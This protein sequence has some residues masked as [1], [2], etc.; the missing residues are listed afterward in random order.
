MNTD[1][2]PHLRADA[3]QN[4]VRIVA[5]ARAAFA[6]DGLDV[7]MNEIARRA[8]VGQGTL[9]RRFPTKEALIDEVFADHV[10]HC[11]NMVS[12]GLR[13]PDPWRGFCTVVRKM[14]M[15]L[16][17]DRSFA[18]VLTTRVTDESSVRSGRRAVET[19]LEE[20]VRRTQVAGRL[21]A[22]FEPGDI[23]LTILANDGV[24]AAV[25]DP[26]A[27]CERLTAYL[28]RAFEAGTDTNALPTA[29]AVGLDDL[30]PP[31]RSGA[32]GRDGAGSKPERRRRGR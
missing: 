15:A 1:G 2:G 5:A 26:R 28:L 8:G 12:A 24:A 19:L 22:D 21:R 32:T 29:I 18:V 31:T 9:Y 6:S 10:E 30:K 23:I 11:V 16:S 14:A 27:A 25:P 20:L 7:P 3:I 4:R 17:S 13:D